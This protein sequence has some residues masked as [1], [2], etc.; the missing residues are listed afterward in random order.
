MARRFYSNNAP[1]LTTSGSITAGAT[2]VG[3]AGSFSGWPVQFPFY[4]ALDIGTASFEI[5]SV[6][7]I[8][9]TTATIVRAQDGT[10][11]ISHPA[12]AT[13]DQVVVRQDLDEANAHVV[14][15]TGVHG[16]SGAVVGTS[17]NQNLTNKTVTSPVLAGTATG[18]GAINTSGA[19]T[20]SAGITGGSLTT[21]GAVTAASAA[22]SGAA[23]AGS[24][25]ANGNGAVTGVL[26]PK[27]YT[28]EAAATAAI[29]SPVTGSQVWLTAP[30]GTGYTAGLFSYTGSAW[31]PSL[32]FVGR[33]QYHQTTTQ[34]LTNGANT[35]I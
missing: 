12:G 17:D 28:N 18:A 16:I 34:A 22:V 25:A 1:Q 13:L 9:G 2:T 8:V 31:V 32:G 10:A 3:V 26:V 15:S 21:G 35:V 29:G 7:N 6:T 30:T 5:V 14:A 24:V 19:I 4:A 33:L 27:T 23:T 11:A 20:T